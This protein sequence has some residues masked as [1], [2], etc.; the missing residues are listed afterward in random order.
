L[1]EEPAISIRALGVKNPCPEDVALICPQRELVVSVISE[2]LCGDGV[3][4]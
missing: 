1:A 2:F 4:K 3:M